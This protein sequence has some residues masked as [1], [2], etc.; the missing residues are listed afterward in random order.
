MCYTAAAFF[1]N[2]ISTEKDPS[3][4]DKGPGRPCD[5]YWVG[6]HKYCE[7]ESRT[8][9]HA[10]DEAHMNAFDSA[11]GAAQYVPSRMTPVAGNR[12]AH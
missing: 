12:F 4:E 7:E 8:Q 1:R 6:G 10:C 9:Y 3:S 2:A 5:E 11:G